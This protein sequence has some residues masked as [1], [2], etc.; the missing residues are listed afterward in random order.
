MSDIRYRY[1]RTGWVLKG[2]DLSVDDGEYLLIGGGNGS[3][4]STLGYICNGLIPHHFGGMLQGSV[5][6]AGLNTLKQNVSDLFVYVGLVLQN[7]DAQLFNSTV[8]DE[9]AFGLESLGV[10]GPEIGERIREISVTLG[11]EDLLS[12]SPVTLSGGEKRLVAVASVLVLNPSVLLLDEPYGDLDWAASE[13]VRQTLLKINQNGKTVIVTEQRLGNLLED[14]TG[15][16]ILDEGKVLYQ[17]IAQHVHEALSRAHLLPNYSKRHNKPVGKATLLSAR[18]LSYRIG[19]KEIL[20]G[21]SFDLRKGESVALIGRN[22]SG[23]TT[24]LKHF[25]GLLKPSAGKVTF[26]GEDIRGKSPSEMAAHVGLSFQNPNDQFFKY[27]VKDEVLVGPRKLGKL[28]GEWTKEMW[29]VFDLHGLLNRSPYRLSEGEKKR[30]S[31]ASILAMRPQLLILDEPT[32][33]QDGRFREALAILLAALDNLDFTLLIATHDLEFAHAIADRWIVLH[34][35]RVVGDGSPDA[36]WGDK[37]L[38]QLGALPSPEAG[39]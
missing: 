1:P 16:L 2:I 11:L 3:G 28:P 38:V 10:P 35:G 32:S 31:L 12:R 21:V 30:V 37:R 20:T 39:N 18:D 19:E 6:V 24:L 26:L 5:T 7:A 23:K 33:G 8:E 4:K 17:G 36:L 9:I 25:N 29:D 34:D 15:C 14:A 27:R 22:G 13:K